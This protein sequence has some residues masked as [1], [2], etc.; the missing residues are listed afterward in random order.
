[1]AFF[2]FGTLMDCEVLERVLDRPVAGGEVAPARLAGFRRVR[3]ARGTYPLLVPGQDDIVEGVL[4]RAASP[5]D[6]R[7]ITHFEGEEYESRWLT[8]RTEDGAPLRARVFFARA[9]IGRTDEPWDLELWAAVHKKAFL[10]QCGDWMRG[11][12]P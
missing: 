3:S 11:C 10:E 5:R 8:V 2:F 1:L 7:R 6:A 4:L 9:A 12:P